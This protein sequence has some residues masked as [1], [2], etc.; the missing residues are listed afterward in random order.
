MAVRPAIFLLLATLAAAAAGAGGWLAVRQNRADAA[1]E[2]VAAASPTGPG[3]LAP[4]ASAAAGPAPAPAPA[5]LA[6]Q[7]PVAAAE[8][9][10]AVAAEPEPPVVREPEVPASQAAAT[11]AATDRPAPARTAVTAEAAVTAPDARATPEAAAAAPETPP[12]LP[13]T[14]P[15]P[16][17]AA[18]AAP[19]ADRAAAVAPPTVPSP[20]VAWRSASSDLPRVD[21]WVRSTETAVPVD[22]EPLPVEQLVIGADSVI[23]LQVETTVSSA[24]A[25]VE[26][27]VDARVTRDVMVGDRV[28][29]PAGTRVRGSVVLVEQAG[30]L[31]GTP[32]LGVRFHTAFMDDGAELPITTETVYREGPARGSESTR[33]IGGAA[34]GGAILGAIFGG[35][36]G[37]AIGSAAGAAGGTAMAVAHNGPPASFPAGA[38]VTIRLLNSAAVRVDRLRPGSR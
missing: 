9:V 36:R 17:L 4:R 10:T 32:R 13:V 19:A 31:R 34:V 20:D 16:A 38:R 28:A 5:P 3:G 1:S 11:A 29:I 33:R 24:A 6:P 8:P 22:A 15:D 27:D 26:D 30:K 7:A 14:A 2:G 37:A 21:G 35:R 23:G 12:D 25:E 18:D